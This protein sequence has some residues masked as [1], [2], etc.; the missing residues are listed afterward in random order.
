MGTSFNFAA[1]CEFQSC[2]K[3][4]EYKNTQF[5][6]SNLAKECIG[7]SYL[8]KFTGRYAFFSKYVFTRGPYT[9][10]LRNR[11]R[12]CPVVRTS[13]PFSHSAFLD[14]S[15]DRL[16]YES[17]FTRLSFERS[18]TSVAQFE[19]Q[20][21]ISDSAKTSSD[22]NKEVAPELLRRVTAT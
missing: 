3:C 10:V 12:V 13:W 5:Y 21:A 4:F 19:A 22:R 2:S 14:H 11:R 7:R 20:C 9:D 1:L 8:Q 18:S 15:S 17:N 16:V 6:K